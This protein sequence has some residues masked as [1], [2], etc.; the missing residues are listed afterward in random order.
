[1]N[2]ALLAIKQ[3]IQDAGRI[4]MLERSSTG[5]VAVALASALMT[6]TIGSVVAADDMKY[7]NWKGQW[8]LVINRGLGGQRVT[9]DP[10]KPWGPG[11]QAPL[12]PEYQKVLE[13]SMAD[14]AL[15][16]QG[17]YPTARCLPGGMPRMMAHPK[18]EYVVTPE[19]TYILL[20]GNDHYRRIFTDGRAWPKDL[21]PTYQGVSIGKWIDED[22]DG[23][24]DVLEVETRGPFKGPRAYDATGLPLHFD[25]ESVFKERFFLDK[26]NPNLLHDVIT[27]Y[28]HALTRPWTADKTWVRN[29][30]PHPNWP[31]A[32][33]TEGNAQIM[34]GTENYFLS[35]DGLLMPAKKN[36]APPDLRYFKQTPK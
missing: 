28:D 24:Y 27:V 18:Q 2:V 15:G 7:P 22:G 1:V 30:N 35:G 3:A 5:V 23:I 12:T 6:M 32:F 13:A 19:S 11:Q 10:T 9:F 34:I 20:G 14:Q 17:N 26:A 16:G 29:P 25:N 4:F 33:C 21:E 36:Q 31:E 8:D